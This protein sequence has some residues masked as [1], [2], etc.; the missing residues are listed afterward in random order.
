MALSTICN[1]PELVTKQLK[2]NTVKDKQKIRISSN[3]LAMMGWKAD[4]RIQPVVTKDSVTFKRDIFGDLKV[5]QRTYKHRSNNPQETVI[6][7]ANQKIISELMGVNTHFHA[8]M[9]P[10]EIVIKAIKNR[11]FSIIDRFKKNP[12]MTSCV[13][14]SAGLDATSLE[15]N[16]FEI[17]VLADYRPNEKR[18]TTDKT[19]T[20][21][22]MATALTSPKRVFNESIYDL[23]MDNL[24]RVFRDDPLMLMVMSPVCKSFSAMAT[25]A[26]KQEKINNLESTLDMII[27]C[28]EA[29]KATN[30]ACVLIE[31]VVAFADNPVCHALELNLR[32]I[33]YNVHK[34]IID[35]LAHGGLSSR[36][37]CYIVATVFE[38][39]EFPEPQPFTG[40][41]WPLINKHF[42][43]CKDATDLSSVKK[44]LLNGRARII[45]E[46]K[47]FSPT[48]M[49]SQSRGT[50]DAVRFEKDGRIYNPSL[51]LCADIMGV[52]DFPLDLLSG[53]SSY[54]T[55]GN[56]VDCPS[57]SRLVAKIVEHLQANSKK[58]LIQL[59][60]R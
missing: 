18:D 37:R 4:E 40:N 43:D 27:P 47:T 3:F 13:M 25:N 35:P 36:K 42:G 26:D 46:D 39:F 41:V 38:H 16:G 12:K 48:I 21:A 6:E 59:T 30:P 7:L 20:A 11:A 10:N 31:Q 14:M 52:K 23:N 56:G 2:L 9:T 22:L 51:G 54:E 32:R 5:H 53:E 28:L 17:S 1:A 19:E 55:L 49:A 34:K 45:S 8:S 15:H 50:K 57:H 44:S 29:V 58:P 60:K 33:G 24:E